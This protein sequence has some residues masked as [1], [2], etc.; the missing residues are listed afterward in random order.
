M[1]GDGR[2][3]Q[4]IQNGIDQSIN[5]SFLQLPGHILGVEPHP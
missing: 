1:Q 4:G 5:L 2:L 3:S